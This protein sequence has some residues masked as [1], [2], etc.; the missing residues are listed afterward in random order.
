MD[1]ILVLSQSLKEHERHPQSLLNR[2]WKYGIIVNPTKGIF[3][4]PKITF[5]GVKASAEHFQ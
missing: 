4:A 1:N 5:L 3:R 2:I